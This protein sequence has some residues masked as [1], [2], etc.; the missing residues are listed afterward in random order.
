MKQVRGATIPGHAA[1][2]HELLEHGMGSV[3]KEETA[4]V[5]Q[6]GHPDQATGRS[7]PT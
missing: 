2:G 6:S 1:R 3:G 5:D 4:S 7:R